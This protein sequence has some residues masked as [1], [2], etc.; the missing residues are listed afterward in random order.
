MLNLQGE[1][2]QGDGLATKIGPL[3]ETYRSA[4]KDVLDVAQSDPASATLLT[5]AADSSADKLLTALE[6][7]KAGADLFR[8][9]SSARTSDLVTRGY[10]WL[11]IILCIALLCS[12]AASTLVTRAIVKP[13]MELTDVIHLI[14]GGKTDVSIPGLDRRDEIA[15]IAE[16]TKLCRDNMVIAARLAEERESE[17]VRARRK[18][19]DTLEALNQGF[20]A[21]AGNLVSTFLSAASDLKANAETMTQVTADTGRR[22]GEVKAASEETSKNVSEVANATEEAF[23][24]PSPRSTIGSSARWK[25]RKWP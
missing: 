5:F 4:A 7:F 14:A 24:P 21:T 20:Q 22:A 12:V 25:S 6:N 2:F 13:I 15:V 16:A 10:W 9:Q 11:S 17:Q 18:R 1:L 23:P 8:A 3:F 19:R